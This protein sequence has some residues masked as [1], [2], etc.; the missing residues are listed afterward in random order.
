MK[1]NK[2]LYVIWLWLLTIVGITWVSA[3]RWDSSVQWP[4]YSEERHENMLNAFETSDY[5]AWAS[6]MDGKGR[7]TEV[8]NA[9]NFDQFVEAHNLTLE[10][11]IEEADAIRTELGLWLKDW[12]G[13]RKGQWE[14]RMNGQRKWWQGRGTCA[15]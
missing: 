7:V 12:S 1:N 8:I 14:S 10:W 9:D 11:N 3:Y 13:Q 5:E 2:T 4:N 6:L 15:Q